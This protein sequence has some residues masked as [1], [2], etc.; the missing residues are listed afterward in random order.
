VP[1]S[2]ESL[3]LA[4]GFRRAELTVR[5]DFYRHMVA[6]WPLAT[7]AIRDNDGD[8]LGD[9][10]RLA[11]LLVQRFRDQSATLAQQYVL[12][13]RLLDVGD[14]G[15]SVSIGDM[16]DEQIVRTLL[17]TGPGVIADGPRLGKSQPQAERDALAQTLAASGQL[18]LDG[19]HDVVERHVEADD[20]AV[21]WMR[22]TD[23]DPCSFCAMLA[24]RGAVYSTREAAG[25]T[26]ARLDADK[27]QP[28]VDPLSFASEQWHNG[29]GCAVVPVFTRRPVLPPS[30][31]QAERLWIAATKGLS[32]NDARNAYRRAVEGRPHPDDPIKQPDASRPADLVKPETVAPQRF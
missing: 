29:C 31:V 4:E 16:P 19:G 13:A 26:D 7:A 24:S 12:R 3:T 14:V 1:A 22:V 10:L 6:L 28:G 18:V 5:A 11:I 20:A 21:G 17:A 30:S 9:W 25:G 8:K 15:P 27:V 23:G 32:G 2:T